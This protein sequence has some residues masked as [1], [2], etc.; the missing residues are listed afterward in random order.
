MAIPIWMAGAY[1]MLEDQ[2]VQRI[3]DEARRFIGTP[4][5]HQ[6]SQ[7]GLGCDCL[8]LVRGVWHA[9]YGDEPESPGA[10]ERGWAIPSGDDILRDA[11][12]R[13]LFEI[14]HKRAMSCS[15][16]GARILQRAILASRRRINP[17][18]TRM[19][20]QPSPR[21]LSVF[22]GGNW[23]MHFAFQFDKLIKPNAFKS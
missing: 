22:G 10:Y 13:H 1:S 8:G 17:W 23:L 21:F 15:F 7:C 19:K 11:A 18:C 2:F 20:V 5:R 16:V 3:V 9:L 6:A 4:Y 12:R 14:D